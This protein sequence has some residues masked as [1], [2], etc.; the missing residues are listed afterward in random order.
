MKLLPIA[1]VT[2]AIVAGSG[3]AV[4]V[5]ESTH[6]SPAAGTS[7]VTV[8]AAPGSNAASTSGKSI[9]DIYQAT[10][11]GV[12]EITAQTTN[13]GTSPFESPGGTAQGTGFVVDSQGNIVTN[14]HVVAGASS[15][16]V[17]MRDGKTYTGTIVGTDE[18]TDI[19]VVHID[20]PASALHPLPLGDSEAVS[21]GETVVA[22]GNP[23]GLED[24]VTAGIVSAL[25]RT[26]TSPN[27]R[28]ITG[29][30]QTDAAINHGNSGGPL[31]NDQGEVIGVTSQIYADGQTSGNVG[32]GFAVP[33]N[34][35]KSIMSQLISTGSAEHASIGIY[36]T[37]APSG[38][39]ITRVKTGS[40]GEDA[41]LKTGDVITAVDG[42]SVASPEDLIS[43]VSAKKPGDHVQ[44]SVTSNGSSRTVDV[45]LGNSV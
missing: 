19:A 15:V 34:T 2:A 11:D 41:G 9:S 42:T 37:T 17:A 14:A 6:G 25:D 23:F 1:A 38:V 29:A 31:L 8:T 28:P 45:T 21:V 5:A 30:I 44:L 16:K 18:T 12:V 43:I 32:I 39:E 24:T 7:T 3:L 13:N 35:V 27:N 4:A 22:I 40:P 33:S 20:A 10:A 36:L 26:I